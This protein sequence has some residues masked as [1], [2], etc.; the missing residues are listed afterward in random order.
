MFLEDVAKT[1]DNASAFTI[2][3]TTMSFLSAVLAH[4]LPPS[5]KSLTMKLVHTIIIILILT[6]LRNGIR[7]IMKKYRKKT[8][9]DEDKELN[10][11]RRKYQL[12]KLMLSKKKMI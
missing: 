8:E 7:M 10:E 6:A 11:L 12:Q 2:D 4:Y 3:R 1:V 9:D 5:D